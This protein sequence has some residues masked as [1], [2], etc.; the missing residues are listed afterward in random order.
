[1]TAPTDDSVLGKQCAEAGTEARLAEICG[2]VAAALLKSALD[3]Q[4][5][6]RRRLP[7]PARV[8]EALRLYRR[9]LFAEV[10]T[11]GGR[12][13]LEQLQVLAERLH[14]LLKD[15][16]YAERMAQ[17]TREGQEPLDGDSDLAR[18]RT[19]LWSHNCA[20]RLVGLLPQVRDAMNADLEAF[21]RGDPAA[22]SR[23]EIIL[24]YP[25][26]RAIAT[27]RLAHVMW[28]AG[29][30]LVARMM[31]EQAHAKTGIDLH[32]GAMIGE[33]FFIDHGTG[34][35]VGETA[36]IGDNVRLY[37]GVTIGALSIPK[38]ADRRSGK[39]HP[40]LQD[41]AIVYANAT[42]LGGDTV[43]GAGAIVGGNAWVTTSVPPGSR[44]KVDVA[45]RVAETVIAVAKGA[46]PE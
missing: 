23:A 17:P 4:G 2:G 37:Q 41:G 20:E 6:G 40:T 45:P 11:D 35:V 21:V 32:P 28:R 5:T 9:M 29:A 18:E 22:R 30:R 14:C 10:W 12:P 24:T 25:G 13:R 8:D 26:F 39:R 19:R 44:M 42:I 3:T 15:L 34:V 36:V 31:T 38:I 43:I 46:Q 1:M 27:Y 7:H 16:V 33:G